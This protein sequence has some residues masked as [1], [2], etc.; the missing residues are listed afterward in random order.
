MEYQT[1]PRKWKLL[2]LQSCHTRQ[3]QT[4]K[5]LKRRTAAESLNLPRAAVRRLAR[6]WPRLALDLGGAG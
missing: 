4:F 5:H 2:I 3:I 6:A 1:S